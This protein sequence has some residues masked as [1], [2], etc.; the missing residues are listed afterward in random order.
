MKKH[1]L[2]LL[3]VFS[4][5]IF[6]NSCQD[7]PLDLFFE[8]QFPE[9]DSNVIYIDGSL[10]VPI[11]DS[12]FTLQDF[13]PSTDSSLWAEVDQNNLVH[14]RMYFKDA[15]VL[16][17]DQIYPDYFV[18]GND[19]VP[20]NTIIHRD[21]ASGTSD[22]N[23][24]KVY[25]SALSGH[26]FFNDPRIS[27]IF[28]NEIPIVTFFRL[29]SLRFLR[30]DN[31][32]LEENNIGTYT[33]D[34][35]TQDGEVA[36]SKI[37]FTKQEIPSLENLFA[38]I[39]KRISVGITGGSHQD[40]STPYAIHQDDK[41]SLDVD[42]DLPLIAH[43]NDLILGDTSN[44][45]LPADTAREITAIT[46]KL[47]IDNDF[48]VSGVGQIIFIDSTGN[49]IMRV[50]D[51]PGWTFD[52][53]Q[54]DQQ[55]ISTESVKSQM[56]KTLTHEQVNLLRDKNVAKAIMTVRLNSPNSQNGFDVRIYGWYKIGVKL[57][58][59]IDY[60]LSH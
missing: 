49:E 26:L 13:I 9:T 37:T 4:V 57:G 38:P 58:V 53:A 16:T 55:G 52:A 44:F 29:D 31:T 8:N 42:I 23:K 18:G 47:I 43:L 48:P 41:L 40:Q 19:V 2:K 21:S 30:P 54:V 5:I 17:A 33:I 11:L 35:P 24:L 46:L 27:F 36:V 34:A 25:Q 20:A 12:Y 32:I 14:L 28:K 1:L 39:P 15:V 7:K 22:W 51:N 3:T 60:N 6:F 59:K 56:I 10:A 50:F 45:T